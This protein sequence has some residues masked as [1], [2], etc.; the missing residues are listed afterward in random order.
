MPDDISFGEWL[1]KELKQRRWS[2]AQLANMIG[3]SRSVI[4]RITNEVNKEQDPGTCLAIA[5]LLNYSPVTVFRIAK[6]LPPEPETL[7]LDDFREALAHLSPGEQAE[8]LKIALA[9]V[10]VKLNSEKGG[11]AAG[12]D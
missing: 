8:V 4:G 11:S 12:L 10:S 2:Q 9:I 6:I 7:P 5:R 3:K 1:Q